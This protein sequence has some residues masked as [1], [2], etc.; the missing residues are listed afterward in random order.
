[1]LGGQLSVTC[2]KCRSLESSAIM[3]SVCCIFHVLRT[4]DFENVWLHSSWFRLCLGENQ[5]ADVCLLVWLSKSNLL[6][7]T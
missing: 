1:M 3:E 7:N 2:P 6:P 4:K 5:T